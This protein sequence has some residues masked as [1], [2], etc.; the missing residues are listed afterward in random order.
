MLNLLLI[1]PNSNHAYTFQTHAANL[2]Y[3]PVAFTNTNEAL[4]VCK[5]LATE[6]VKSSDLPAAIVINY[7]A[8]TPVCANNNIDSAENNNAAL[9]LCRYIRSQ[10][11][12]P[13]IPILVYG[14]PASFQVTAKVYEAGATH[15][16]TTGLNKP[17]V[18]LHLLEMMLMTGACRNAFFP[19]KSKVSQPATFNWQP[20]Q[21]ATLTQTVVY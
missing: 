20:A 11:H 5:W 9:D 7:N 19:Q 17:G 21:H 3:R 13:N 8:N 15:Y 10:V 6:T 1:E 4:T 18:I 16:C 14:G 12:L 2:Y